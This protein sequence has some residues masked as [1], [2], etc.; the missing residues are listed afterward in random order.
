MIFLN[1]LE[2]YE[3]H[4]QE[5]E[6]IEAIDSGTLETFLE[7]KHYKRINRV[8]QQLS[9]DNS[10]NY[11]NVKHVEKLNSEEYIFYNSEIITGLK[12]SSSCKVEYEEKDGIQY[13]KE[14]GEQRT[15]ESIKHSAFNSLNRT[16]QKI[17]DYALANNWENGY[18]LTITFNQ[19]YVDRYNYKEC[20]GHI[21]NLIRN[22]RR[23]NPN[24]KY[25][26]VPEKHKDG[27]WHF[28]GLVVNCE[29]LIL[30][31]SGKTAK[32]KKIYNINLQTYKYGFTTAT[33]I[34]D[35]NKVSGYITK[36][37]TKEL[38]DSTKGQHRYLFS[39]NL[40]APTVSTEWLTEADEIELK[41]M[42]IERSEK[43][44]QKKVLGEEDAPNAVIYYRLKK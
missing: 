40:D 23:T 5:Q 36:Y 10:I 12:R 4:L 30:I 37:I 16:K 8:K 33:K 22:I 35:T 38:I 25:I 11:Y 41:K 28:H 21:K 13:N 29:N 34:E 24:I 42:I 17:Y 26:F 3:K 9:I 44:E 6:L 1:V 27:A 2:A 7:R 18:F 31:D 43:F 15:E 14:T 39:K 32:G 20:Y 19:E